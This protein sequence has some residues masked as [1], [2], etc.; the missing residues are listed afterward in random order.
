MVE[1]LWDCSNNSIHVSNANIY[2]ELNE[3]EQQV[4]QDAVK[5][6]EG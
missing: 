5:E 1:D 6:N 4:E 2:S 3:K